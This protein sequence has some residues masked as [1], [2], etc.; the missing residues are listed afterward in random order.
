[1]ASSSPPAP[2]SNSE[3]SVPPAKRPRV[4]GAT[5]EIIYHKDTQIWLSDGNIILAAREDS[6]PSTESD[7]AIVNTRLFKCHRGTLARH[8]VVFQD[9]FECAHPE[10]GEQLDDTPLMTLWD[11][12]TDVKNLLKL[13]YD[14]VE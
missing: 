2:E 13:L 4:D 5:S 9:L 6:D 8:S 11:S 12:A 14:P 1:M 3:S 7:P 10:P